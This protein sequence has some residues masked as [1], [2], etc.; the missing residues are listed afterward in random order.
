MQPPPLPTDESARRT[1]IVRDRYRAYVT[2]RIGRSKRSGWKIGL[3]LLLICTIAAAPVGI[4]LF[5]VGLIPRNPRRTEYEAELA[6]IERAQPVVAFPLMVNSMLRAPGDRPAPGLVIISFDPAADSVAAMAEV[7][8]AAGEP[9]GRG[10]SPED[11][12]ALI[13]LMLDEQYQPSRRR[14]LPG[15]VT[16]GARVYACD[17]VIHPLLLPDRHLSD[18]V[19]FVACLAEPGE[20][21]QIRTIPYWC[22][23]DVPPPPWEKDAPVM[24]A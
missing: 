14:P 5:I 7:A 21:G 12:A 1:R 2:D 24:I 6:F 8:L 22:A 17:L 3:G 10:L 18:D 13:E 11:E 23:F 4:G 9:V 20:R 16:K 15:S 19:P